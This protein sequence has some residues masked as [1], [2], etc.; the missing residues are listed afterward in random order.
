MSRHAQ[1]GGVVMLFQ[2]QGSGKSSVESEASFA[3]FTGP[4][5]IMYGPDY[6]LAQLYTLPLI[7]CAAC[8]MLP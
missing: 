8:S 1:C 5:S 2:A 6:R 3:S 7:V 4:V